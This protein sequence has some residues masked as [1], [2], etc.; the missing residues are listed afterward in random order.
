[1]KSNSLKQ[2]TKEPHLKL[3][4]NNTDEK[5]QLKSKIH[6]IYINTL[7]PNFN[8]INQIGK[9]VTPHKCILL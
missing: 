9:L 1:M 8:Y 5:H 7:V 6:R 2:I 3:V 4:K